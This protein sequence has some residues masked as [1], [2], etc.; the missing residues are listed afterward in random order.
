MLK[1][2]QKTSL[3]DYPG[4]MVSTVFFEGCNFRCPFCHNKTLVLPEHFTGDVIEHDEVITHLKNNSKF[5]DGI[6]ITGGEPTLSKDLI[7][8]AKK[9]KSEGFLVKLDTNGTNPKVLKQLIDDSLVDYIAMDI[10]GPYKNYNNIT[11][12]TVELDKVKESIDLI[13][14]SNVDHEFRTTVLPSM[15]SSSDILETVKQLGGCKRFSLQQFRPNE[16]LDEAYKKESSYSREELDN[17]KK[18]ILMNKYANECIVR[19]N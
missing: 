3:V 14:N 13:K 11:Q 17:L 15:H 16:T 5:L 4:K 10:K 6:C 18:E 19:G 7:E 8:F 2:L 1:G 12:S 9:V